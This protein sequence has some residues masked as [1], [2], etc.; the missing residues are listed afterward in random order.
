MHLYRVIDNARITLSAQDFWTQLNYQLIH[1]I[2]FL[3]VSNWSA[4][5]N[6]TAF[7]IFRDLY[8]LLDE[9]GRLDTQLS[10]S[11]A[12]T[13]TAIQGESQSLGAKIV[14]MLPVKLSEKMAAKSVRRFSERIG[15]T[16]DYE[17]VWT[18]ST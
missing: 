4:H 12:T 14:D 17:V 11:P 2:D 5:A 15:H 6:D 18:E 1:L 13:G 9:T 16:M 8:A 3:P 10:Y 7:I